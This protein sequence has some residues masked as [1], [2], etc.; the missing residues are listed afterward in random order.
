VKVNVADAIVRLQK[1]LNTPPPYLLSDVQMNETKKRAVVTKTDGALDTRVAGP[2]DSYKSWSPFRSLSQNFD[3]FDPF[4][5]FNFD[6][7]DFL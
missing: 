5:I 1:R 2:R 6:I 4:N 7:L 3:N